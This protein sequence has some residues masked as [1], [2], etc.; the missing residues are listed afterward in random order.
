VKKANDSSR[1]GTK[2]GKWT[3]KKVGIVRGR[4]TM[5]Q[6]QCDCGTEKFVDR[7]NL[8]GG[9]SKGC[10]RCRGMSGDKNPMW[11]GFGEVPQQLWYILNV[12][13]EARGLK[14]GVKIEDLDRLFKKQMG[15]CA[16]TGLPLRLSTKRSG[17]T[18]SVDRINSEKG[19]V[20]GNIQWVHKDVNMMK[21]N[22]SEERF[23][24]IC[25]LVAYR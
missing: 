13:A 15:E 14:V 25:R 6:C 1:I 3:V 5:W 9:V 17:C 10:A 2:I 20:R 23:K 21:N 11:K 18:A 7:N 24:E 4:K 16:L 19:Y 22:F 8:V 12:G